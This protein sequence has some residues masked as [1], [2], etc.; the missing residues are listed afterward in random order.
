M[1][2][3]RRHRGHRSHHG[4]RLGADEP[5]DRRRLDDVECRGRL[6][7]RL[8]RRR[9]AA[10]RLHGDR[11]D[12]LR[13]LNRLRRLDGRRV[14]RNGEQRV[15]VG[16]S[17]VGGRSRRR[18]L[19]RRGRRDRDRRLRCRHRAGVRWRRGGRRRVGRRHVD[20]LRRGL[21]RGLRQGRHRSRFGRGGRNGGRWR[22]DRLR[23][24]RG[25]GCGGSGNGPD[26]Q[27]PERVDVALR[28]GGE[29][30]AEIDG[31]AST[32]G[33]ERLALGDRGAA[34]N[35]ERAEVEERHRVAV[36]REDRQRRA[37]SGNGSCEGD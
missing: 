2:N 15:R 1:R 31:A 28:I 37:A 20:R 23:H 14:D 26:G 30:D 3:S 11:L 36:R 5:V 25:Y 21:G 35:R 33:S 7:A 12:G 8:R 9:L 18:W 16:R 32:G 19:G 4:A 6:A 13:G 34:P 17:R 29:A 22:R 24:G 10:C 27:E